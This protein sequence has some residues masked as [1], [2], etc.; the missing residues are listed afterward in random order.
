LLTLFKSKE[1][2]K[3]E[4][5]EEISYD[6]LIEEIKKKDESLAERLSLYLLEEVEVIERVKDPYDKLKKIDPEFAKI[7]GRGLFYYYKFQYN[8]KKLTLDN[9]FAK[10]IDLFDKEI[11]AKN[12]KTLNQKLQIPLLNAAAFQVVNQRA[13][14]VFFKEANEFA[15]RVIN[16]ITY[17]SQLMRELAIW[18][19]INQLYEDLISASKEK[20]DVLAESAMIEIKNFWL[21]NYDKI[22]S[23]FEL[24]RYGFAGI[25]NDFLFFWE[26]NIIDLL[27]S[28]N[29]EE[30]RRGIKIALTLVR[31]N[32]LKNDLVASYIKEESESLLEKYKNIKDIIG[33]IE[34]EELKKKSIEELDKKIKEINQLLDRVEKGIKRQIPSIKTRQRYNVLVSKLRTFYDWLYTNKKIVKAA[35]LSYRS[36]IRLNLFLLYENVKYLKWLLKMYELS[37]IH[38]GLNPLNFEYQSLSQ[39]DF[40]LIIDAPFEISDKMLEELDYS[41]ENHE[42]E[43]KE[44]KLVIFTKIFLEGNLNFNQEYNFYIPSGKYK[45][46]FFFSLLKEEELEKLRL[47]E[48]SK[49]LEEVELIGKEFIENFLR[50]M[51]QYFEL[52]FFYSLTDFYKKKNYFS[53]DIVEIIEKKDPELAAKIKKFLNKKK[54]KK[55]EKKE[56]KHENLLT[57]IIAYII[58]MLIDFGKFLNLISKEKEK[59]EEKKKT[60]SLDEIRKKIIEKGVSDLEDLLKNAFVKG[61]KEKFG[62]RKEFLSDKLF[63]F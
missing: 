7:L 31:A 39:F 44:L 15:L 59:K 32:L 62:V 1:E 26:K 5:E 58:I 35:Y 25:V 30:R 36:L 17:L 24:Q 19:R 46:E 2:K 10:I 27:L 21:N 6:S 33:D 9:F 37:R 43:K 11:G 45:M 47:I 28:D 48:I 38:E 53:K 18:E 14:G 29:I 20:N 41:P 13:S 42:L 34:N 56:K 3:E 8:N 23:L 54:E 22:N 50:E 16:T 49:E 55:E 4:K 57:E 40:S 63:K 12:I 51:R 61:I 60:L 52:D